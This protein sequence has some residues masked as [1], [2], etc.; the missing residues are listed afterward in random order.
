MPTKGTYYIN[1]PSFNDATA[2]FTDTDLS[3]CAP[4]G[5]YSFGGIVRQQIGCQ[6]F[7]ATACPSC[8]FI[9]LWDTTLVSTG[10]STNRQVKLPLVNTGSYNFTVNWGDGR[11]DLITSWNQA[12]TLH[13]YDVAGSYTI[14]ITGVIVGWS[15][16]LTGDKLKL[17]EIFQ[18]GCFNSGNAINC[19]A[20]CNNLELDNVVDTLDLTGV[21][22]LRGF[23][24]L[25]TS[26]TTINRVNEWNVSGVRNFF[27][28]FF[29]CIN[30][31]DNVNDWD[32]SNADTY[33]G[34]NQAEGLH[35]MFKNCAAFNQPLNN[36]DLTNVRTI[37]AM[38]EG[39]VSFNQ[40]ITMWD[41]GNVRDFQAV[42][43]GA[44]AFNF[45]L[46][47]WNVSNALTMVQFMNGKTDLDYSTGNFDA[48]LIGWSSQALQS[49]ITADFGTIKYTV[50][51]QAAETLIVSTY[52]WTINSGGL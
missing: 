37:N 42:F 23:F 14:I 47:T 51:G 40:D 26:L 3:I 35:G 16:N 52:G 22:T 5:Y 38:F 28:M 48:T 34:L 20:D 25:C 18:W 15:F 46:G 1:A 41:V 30:F 31:N 9:S 19:F 29:N 13:T 50:A 4:D 24:W 43:Q 11:S 45:A 12:E 27:T 36:W 17:V 33:T 7:P 6:L 44:T 21:T 32:V 8:E 10:S 49:G 2:V 39:A